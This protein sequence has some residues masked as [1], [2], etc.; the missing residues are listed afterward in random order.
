M[1]QRK[2][3]W[4]ITEIERHKVN[5]VIV[6]YEEIG[7]KN[8]HVSVTEWHNGEGVDVDVN[9]ETQMQLTWSQWSALRRAMRKVTEPEEKECPQ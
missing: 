7:N 8:Q 2:Y 4:P 9:G 3:N 6:T 1:P 5:N